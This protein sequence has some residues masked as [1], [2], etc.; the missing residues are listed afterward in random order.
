MGRLKD[1]HWFEMARADPSKGFVARYED[2]Y[3]IFR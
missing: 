3:A 2:C 1:K